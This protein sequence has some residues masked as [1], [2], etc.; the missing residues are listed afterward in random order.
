MKKTMIYTT[1]ILIL[2]LVIW[3]ILK[4]TTNKISKDINE[5][6]KP[7]GKQ[8]NALFLEDVDF[9]DGNYVLYIKHK[10]L[11][12]FAVINEESLEANKESLKVNIS[13]ANYLP[14]EGNR[15][16]GV[17]LFKDNELIKRK[18]GG[19][20]KI[21]EIGN[22]KQS[23]IAVNEHLFAGVKSEVK[24]KIALLKAD[25]NAY[26]ISQSNLPNENKEFHFR[27]Y[28]PSI[29][30]P[31]T[32]G[33][34]ENGYEEILTINEIDYPEWYKGNDNGFEEKWS[35]QIEQCIKN[36]A[37]EITDFDLALSKG[38]LGDAYLFD[39]SQNWGGELQNADNEILYLS[40]FIYYQYQAYIGA[41]KKDAEKLLAIDY[42]D[43]I[44]EF[45]RN[46]S[47][48]MAKMKDLIRQS[49]K[50]NL[51]VEKGE[52]GLLD[53]RDSVTTSKTLYEQEYQ[54]NWLE[55]KNEPAG[56]AVYK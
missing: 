7:F 45:D 39:V 42:S 17:M 46:R 13:W 52:V 31:V 27:I 10:E 1:I 41:N 34:D 24:N 28:F 3:A 33:K 8:N 19:I 30:V 51:S 20:F 36:K 50:S 14:G 16:F 44:S 15:S 29:A 26:I 5:L 11:G 12:E 4:F 6:N 32:R 2:I 22:L 21:F 56:D 18:N 35:T 43:C 54:L 49:T 23:A 25:K 53:Y 55:I 40:D 38:T 9:S 48:V 47:K 37:G